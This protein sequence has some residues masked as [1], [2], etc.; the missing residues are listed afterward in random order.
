M[1]KK[2][3]EPDLV[4]LAFQLVAERGWQHLSLTELARRTGLSLASVHR[5]VPNRRALLRALARRLDERMLDVTAT[6]LDG[7]T[8]RERVFEL[9]MRRLDAMAP[10]KAGIRAVA[11]QVPLDPA[12]L[13]MSACTLGR[14]SRALLDVAETGHGPL[15]AMMARKVLAAIYVRVANVWLDDDTPD[16]ARTLAELDHRLQQAEG[17]ARWTGG[18]GR[19]RDAPAAA[20]G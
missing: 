14:L 18:F 6:E 19:R 9:V 17:L 13:A 3:L 15:V 12:L 8:P 10:Y 4:A 20:P 7:M 5:Q 16:L 2:T 11:R 1:A